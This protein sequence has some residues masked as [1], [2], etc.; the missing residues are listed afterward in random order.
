MIHY[1]C[2]C[3][4]W[5]HKDPCT[6]THP[7]TKTRANT[8]TD[9]FSWIFINKNNSCCVAAPLSAHSGGGGS[10]MMP[11][12]LS[13][14][15]FQLYFPK[16][17]NTV[18]QGCAPAKRAQPDISSV[19]TLKLVVVNLGDEGKAN[20]KEWGKPV[21]HFNIE[22][23]V[24]GNKHTKYKQFFCVLYTFPSALDFKMYCSKSLWLKHYSALINACN[25]SL[26]WTCRVELI[27]KLTVE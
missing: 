23:Y 13:C 19:R 20:W 14:G 7:L 6:H 15:V 5:K 16:S 4:N 17:V 26:L 3:F 18:T 24:A 11:F 12:D 8:C 10:V 22:V 1:K 2:C 9:T 25:I 21:I 27:G